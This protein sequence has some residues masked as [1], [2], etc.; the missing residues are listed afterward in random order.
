MHINLSY[1]YNDLAF[2]FASCRDYSQKRDEE[3]MEI[4]MENQLNLIVVVVVILSTA[5]PQKFII[6]S[7]SALTANNLLPHLVSRRHH[8]QLIAKR[9]REELCGEAERKT[10]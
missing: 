1:V 6:Q 2:H 4:M 9:R 8:P 7:H 3:W 5:K 10:A